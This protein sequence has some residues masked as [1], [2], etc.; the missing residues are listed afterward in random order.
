MAPGPS[1]EGFTGITAT[2]GPSTSA[3]NGAL[4]SFQSEFSITNNRFGGASASATGTGVSSGTSATSGTGST[5]TTLSTI[6]SPAS[7]GSASTTG[8]ASGTAGNAASNTSNGAVLVENTSCSG[9]SCS[10]GLKAAVAVPVVVA[11]IALCALIFFFVR[12]RKRQAAGGAISEKR[13]NKK[14]KKWSRHLR[15]FSFDAELLMGGR[16]S[17]T[18]SIRSRDPSLRSQNNSRNGAHSA[19]P[20]LHSIE[21]VAPPYRDAISHATPASPSPLRNVHAVSGAADP[22]PRSASAATAPPP[23]GSIVGNME[24]SETPASS[25]R[26]PFADSTPVSPVDGSPF[27][28]PP[29]NE[30]RPPLSRNSSMY[31][32]VNADDASEVASIRQAQVGR[33]VSARQVNSDRS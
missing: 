12:R 26:N 33:S 18:N 24:R 27:N 23:Y 20:S 31:Q 28:D 21:E 32:S 13:P 15:V 25:V 1:D 9:I 16:F 2:D 19:E 5:P 8:A 10:S 4:A 22:I 11:A 30:T 3:L 14:N 29:E 17:S 6:T 7:D